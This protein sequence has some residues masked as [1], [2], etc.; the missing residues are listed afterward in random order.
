MIR[1][2]FILKS[3][4]FSIS[5]LKPLEAI[6]PNNKIETPPIT[7][8]GIVLNNAETLPQNPNKIAKQAAPINT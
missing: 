6:I 2:R 7:G 8:V 3:T 1:F 4:L 5:I